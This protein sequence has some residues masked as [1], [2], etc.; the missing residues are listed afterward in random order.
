METNTSSQKT[1]PPAQ[2]YIMAVLCLLIGIPVGY[3]IR[4]SASPSPVRTATSTPVSAPAPQAPAAAPAPQ[5]A[6]E[7][8]MPS[9]EDMKRMADKQVEPLMSKLKSD[10]KDAKLLNQIA[11]NYKIAHQFKEAAT[12]FKKALDVD[13]K[14]VGIRDDYASCLY[15]EGDVDGALAQLQKSLKYEPTHPGTLF[16]LG[17]IRWKGKGDAEGAVAAWKELLKTNPNLPQKESIEQLI[18]KAQQNP[19]VAKAQPQN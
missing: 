5:Q 3:F 7:Q 8:A 11:L 10:P 1:W 6:A 2:A 14:N 4:G 15:Y 17:M 9:L 16:N 13:P 18:A 19:D 12:Y